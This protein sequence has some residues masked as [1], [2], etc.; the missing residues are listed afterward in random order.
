MATAEAQRLDDLYRSARKPKPPLTL[1]PTCRQSMSVT[2]ETA[3]RQEM[4][5][6]GG[7]GFVELGLSAY[8]CTITVAPT[9]TRL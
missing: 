2:A 3:Y 1:A 6:F 7:W 8:Y 9:R 4:A 5:V